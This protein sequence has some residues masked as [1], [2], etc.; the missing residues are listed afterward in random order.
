MALVS[1]PRTILAKGGELFVLLAGRPVHEDYLDALFQLQTAM[2]EAKSQF[3]FTAR[4]DKNRRGDY[5]AISV[6]VTHGGGSK[7]SLA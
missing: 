5:K 4:L 1:S 7:V 3:S 6:G 2:A